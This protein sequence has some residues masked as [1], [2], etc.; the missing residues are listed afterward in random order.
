MG[1]FTTS[2][3]LALNIKKRGGKVY[4]YAVAYREEE[5]SYS[6]S[7][8]EVEA[9]ETVPPQ[10]SRNCVRP[11]PNYYFFG[12]VVY[13]YWEI[14]DL[15]YVKNDK[16]LIYKLATCYMG[17]PEENVKILE[18]PSY[19]YLKKQLRKFTQAIKRKDATLYFYYSGHGI[20]DSKG[21]F[22]ILPADASIEDEV[23]LKESG[24]NVEELKRL[25]ARAKGKKVALIDAC[26]ID[27]PWKPAVVVY[28]PNLVDIAMIFST[29]QGQLSNVDKDKRYSAFTRALY[30]MASSGLVNL[31]FDDDGYVEI[32]ELIKPLTNWVRKVSA[33]G[34]QTP[35]VW[36]PKDFEIF[37][38][39]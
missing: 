35:D 17:V 5:Y 38:V 10:P 37:P 30:E 16:Q 1:I 18:N 39:E 36:G 15:D 14:S 29:K 11:D 25:L 13:D 12:V 19:A 26:R 32:K 21:K 33:D 23:A 31:D 8:V 20:L 6:P 34:K 22:Y 4:D 27:P 9:L 7:G 2:T 24:V 28:K 3:K